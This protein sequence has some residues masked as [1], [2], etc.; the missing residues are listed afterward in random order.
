MRRLVAFVDGYRGLEPGD[1]ELFRCVFFGLGLL[2]G[3]DGLSKGVLEASAGLELNDLPSPTPRDV[4]DL[5]KRI[6]RNTHLFEHR[7]RGREDAR[8]AIV[9]LHGARC[10]AQAVERFDRIPPDFGLDGPGEEFLLR[11]GM[12]VLLQDVEDRE[13]QQLVQREAC[14]LL[15]KPD[16]LSVD[17]EQL[18]TEAAASYLLSPPDYRHARADADVEAVWATFKA[19]LKGRLKNVRERPAYRADGEVPARTQRRRRKKGIREEDLATAAYRTRSALAREIGISPTALRRLEDQG[20]LQ[21]DRHGNV[22]AY[23]VAEAAKAI[24]IFRDRAIR[25]EQEE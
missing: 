15:G 4:A 2:Y 17:Q 6:A 3:G 24:R 1:E 12:L 13:V 18:A 23:N 11:A 7:A 25:R 5:A 20:Q 16:T 14:R 9:H 21:P 22:I 10:V 19:A 8:V